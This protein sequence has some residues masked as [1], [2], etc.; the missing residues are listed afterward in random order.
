MRRVKLHPVGAFSHR[1]LVV[2]IKADGGATWREGYLGK[3]VRYYWSTAGDPII[4]VKA[5]PTTGNRPKVPKTDGCRPIMTLP[6]DYSVPTDL[7]YRRYIEEA[8]SILANIG[9]QQ[10]CG[11]LETLLK[12]LLKIN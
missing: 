8:R 1:V 4:K 9:Y 3:V 2:G 10:P 5:H 7:D 12:S 6:D 11:V